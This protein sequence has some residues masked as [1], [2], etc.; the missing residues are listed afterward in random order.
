MESS[1]PLM[2]VWTF[3]EKNG[4]WDL[5]HNMPSTHWMEREETRKD[6]LCIVTQKVTLVSIER[7]FA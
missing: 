5:S 2:R 7:M 1:F 3:E 4:K 6:W